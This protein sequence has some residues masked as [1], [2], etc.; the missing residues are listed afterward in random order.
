MKEK[1]EYVN[2]DIEIIGFENK[3]II[4]LIGSESGGG[5][6]ETLDPWWGSY[7]MITSLRPKC[8]LYYIE[9]CS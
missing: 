9:A 7:E 2:A 3:E 4:T 8:S 5:N 6:D 1:N